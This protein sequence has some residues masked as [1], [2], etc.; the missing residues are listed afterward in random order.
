MA[1]SRRRLAFATFLVAERR[2][3]AEREMEKTAQEAGHPVAPVRD[4]RAR[5]CKHVLGQSLVR[6]FGESYHDFFWCRLPRDAPYVR[7]G[8]VVDLVDFLA[9]GAGDGQRVVAL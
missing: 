3:K 8:S 6:E 7:N 5:D 2:E 9:E 1:Y 4:R